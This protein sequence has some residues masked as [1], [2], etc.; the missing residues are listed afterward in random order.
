MAAGSVEA[1]EHAA[2]SLYSAST[3]AF[4]HCASC[5]LRPNRVLLIKY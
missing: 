3:S 5:S 4:F 2:T 1:N